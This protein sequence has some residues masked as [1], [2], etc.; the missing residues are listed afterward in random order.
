MHDHYHAHARTRVA[1]G[2]ADLLDAE[3]HVRGVWLK[4]LENLTTMGHTRNMGTEA[5]PRA[6]G[7][8]TGVPAGRSRA[9]YAPN[10][11]VDNTLAA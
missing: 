8:Q 7:A 6:L 10:A 1:S 5:G 11:P 4:L 9:E 3:R 2:C